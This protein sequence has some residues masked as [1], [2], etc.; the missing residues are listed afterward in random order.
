MYVKLMSFDRSARH[1]ERPGVRVADLEDELLARRE[2]HLEV[3]AG[4]VAHR[5]ARIFVARRERKRVL[6]RRKRK[7]DLLEFASNKK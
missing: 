5:P 7:R 4:L 3:P 1:A 6:L 2:L